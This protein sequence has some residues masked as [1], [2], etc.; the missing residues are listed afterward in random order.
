MDIASYFANS[1]T[2][3]ASVE[4]GTVQLQLVLFYCNSGNLSRVCHHPPPLNLVPSLWVLPGPVVCVENNEW[5]SPG[6]LVS[7]HGG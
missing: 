7:F 5:L 1:K 6:N 2:A 3:P 4:L